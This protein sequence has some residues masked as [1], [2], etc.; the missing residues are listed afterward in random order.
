LV[1]HELRSGRRYRLWQEELKTPAPPYAGGADVLFVSYYASA[2]LGCY[3]V[4]NWPMPAR[5]LDLFCEFRNCTNGFERPSGSGLIGALTFY[6]QD[7]GGIV[8]K[9]ELQAAL[10]GDTWRGRYTPEQILSYCESDVVALKRLFAVMASHID[11][12]RALL[13]GRYGCAVSAMEHAGV[14]IDG[15]ILL[16]LRQHW[17]GM[18]DRLIVEIDADFQVFDGHTFK[19]EKFV[20][21]LKAKGTPWPLLETG[22]LNL[23]D[24][25][26][27][28]QT[29]LHPWLAPLRELRNS[30]SELRL[31]SLAVGRDNRNRV[32]LSPFATKTSRN[33]PSNSRYVFGPAT[34]IRSLIRPPAGY[35]LAYI[36]WSQ[37]EIAVAAKLSNDLVL[38][39]AYRTGDVYLSFGKQAGLIPPDA[40]KATHKIQRELCKQCFLA[41]NYGQGEHGLAQRIGQPTIVARDLLAAHRRTYKKF[42]AWSD[43]AVDKALLTGELHSVFGWQLHIR[44]NPNPR[45]LRNFLAQTNGAEM[46]RLAACLGT[47]AGLELVAPVHDAFLL[48]APLDRLDAD[49]AAMRTAMGEASQVVLSGFEVGT[50]V[51]A[52]RFPDRYSDVRGAVMWRKVMTLLQQ[53]SNVRMCA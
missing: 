29:K 21:L 7:V 22:R 30:L 28:Q 26:F 48:C 47:E 6:G 9:K 13:R 23:S 12:P 27:R 31:E 16:L 24:E 38:Q 10:G 51:S 39:D 15:E 33:A 17:A 14:P 18:K 3:R 25:T 40:T 5:I 49:I 4:L 41:I 1:A 46:M 43:A 50:E 52:T 53:T 32:M 8:E 11:L 44:E 2:E 35:G 20:N 42:W 19:Y 34:W 37:Q 45:S 36:D